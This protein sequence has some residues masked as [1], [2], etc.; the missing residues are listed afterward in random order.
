V[1]QQMATSSVDYGIDAPTAVRNLV[2][3]GIAG[4][5]AGLVFQSAIISIHPVAR[6][7]LS[8]AGFVSGSSLLVTAGLMIWSSKRGKLLQ[9]DRLIDDLGLTGKEN[10]LDVGCGRGLLLTG[11]ALRLPEGKA[12]G[13]DLWQNVDQSGNS[14]EAAF[15][16]VQ[17]ENVADR[18]EIRTADMRDLPFPDRLMDAVISSLAVHNVPGKEGRARAIREMARVLKRGG[19]LAIQDLGST[20]EYVKTLRDMGWQDV[21]TSGLSF[22]MFPP[23]RTVTGKKP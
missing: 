3:G 8:I 1:K 10:V 2:I 15:A 6:M 17:A 22:L 7:I 11:V 16:N 18:V 9:R 12:F 21:Q 23:V 4:L 14:L 5:F 13:I 19:R 20:R